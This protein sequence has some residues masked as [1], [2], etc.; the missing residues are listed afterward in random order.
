MEI[1]LY[2]T[3][4]YP[5]TVSSNQEF[6]VQISLTP[7]FTNP[8]GEI[9][10]TGLTADWDFPERDSWKID[11]VM[12]A[13]AFNFRDGR[14][15]AVISLSRE[16]DSTPAIF[17]LHAKPISRSDQ[18]SPIHVT[19]WHKGTFLVKFNR[20]VMVN[21]ARAANNTKP[22][23][24]PVKSRANI[25]ILGSDFQSPDLTVYL[26]DGLDPN[27]PEESRL[28][29]TSPYLQTYERVFV[30]PAGMAEW[31]SEYYAKFAQEIT[32]GV[33]PVEMS[34]PSVK[35]NRVLSQ[36]RGFGQQLYQQFA[37]PAFKTAFWR[38]QDKLGSAFQTIQIY[39]NDPILPWELMRPCRAD[40]SD[41][42][43]FLGIEFKIAR[44]H[45][46]EAGNEYDRPPQFLPMREL[47]VVVPEY[48]GS[49][50]L[51]SQKQEITAL[52]LIEGCRKVPGKWAPLRRLFQNFPQGVIHFAGHG[53]VKANA[54]GIYEYSILLEDGDLDVL[55]WRDLSTRKNRAHPFVFLNACEIGQSFKV[56]NFVDGWAPAALEAGASGFVGGLWPLSDKG[57][58]EFAIYFYHELKRRMFYSSANLAEI[59]RDTR[60][61]FYENGD[62]TFLAYV[63]YGDPNFKFYR[64]S[65]VTQK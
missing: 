44:W 59:L 53:K 25:E 60:R 23:T 15:S 29:I 47:V 20:Y 48:G 3:M 54:R 28:V 36:L 7:E 17:Y 65:R 61:L 50:I 13:P 30:K 57:A 38:L 51:P 5:D 34:D 64:E 45:I 19:L 37:P 24:S 31:L 49:L 21:A 58:A 27:R 41:L 40:G 11:V 33:R 4:E 56:A 2:S 63:Y 55:A 8:D 10:A 42:R 26:L 52:Q 46:N 16:G 32:R 14:N 22:D 35:K 9:D 39:T 43:D 18:I 6:A 12:T 1:L 62:P